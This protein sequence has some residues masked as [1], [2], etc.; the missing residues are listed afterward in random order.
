MLTT[1]SIFER[2]EEIR[3]RM[4]KTSTPKKFQDINSLLD[5]AEKGYTFV[6]DAFGVLNVGETLIPGA[7]KRLDQ[8][9]S[10]GCNIR[11]L[12]NAASYDRNG[13]IDKFKRLGLSVKADEIVTS[14]DATLLCLGS[15]T[16]GA[17][18]AP[19]DQLSDIPNDFIRIGHD[20][21]DFD[22]VDGFVFLSSFG[23][24]NNQQKLLTQSLLRRQR[25]VLIANADLVAPRDNGFS[26][27]PG[28]F[29]HLL[30]DQGVK[31]VSFFGKPFPKVYDLLE[32]TLGEVDQD[33]II[34]CGDSLHTDV[35]GAAARGWKTVL[36]TRD[37]LFAGFDT[38]DFCKRS[39]LYPDW[40][41]PSI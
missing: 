32:Q 36:V 1:Y 41:L 12:T 22:F 3:K 40:R 21:S 11:I 27:E 16:W 24:T 26:L 30:L 2:Y 33:K 39:N 10:I 35:I 7:D 15:G 17:I 25:P 5:I 9:R 19:D 34:M 37:G 31:D 6:F 38:R 18:A 23:W 4:P 28:N 13:A 14:R 20:S 29:G 8:L